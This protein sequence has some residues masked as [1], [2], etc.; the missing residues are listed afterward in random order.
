MES[1]LQDVKYSVRMFV[2][3]PAFT[4]IAVLTLALGIGANTAIFSVI[5]SVL[6]RPLPFHDPDGLVQLWETE[7]APGTYPFAGPDY[8]DWQAQNHTLEATSLYTWGRG[9]NASGAGE[10]ESAS[11]ISAQANFFS[12][13]GVQPKLGRTFA[14]GEDQEGKN[15][16]A[17]LSYG[18]WQRHFGGDLG[19]IGKPVELSSETYSVIGVMPRWFN[20]PPAT[21][22]W[23]PIDMSPKNLGN[24]GSH[25]YRALG[26][27]KPGVSINQAQADLT[28]IAKHL[29]QQYPDSNDKVG[30]AVI[31]MKEQITKSSRE[32]LLILLGAVALVLLVACANI[33]NLLLSRATGRRRELAVR[34]ALGAGRWRVVR[35]LLTESVLLALSGAGL[36]LL[37]AW[38]CVNLLQS[39]KTLPIPR[40]NAVQI[41]V[42]VL[43]FT[44][45]AGIFVGI[46]FGLA[47]AL[48]ALKLNLNEELKSSA[49]AAAGPAG[50]RRLL[51]DALVVGEIA[52][53]LALLVGAGLLLR[54]FAL[55]RNAEIGVQ[56]QN[57]L[58]M[59]INLPGKT[60]T[61]L[62]ARREFFDRLLDRIQRTPG[63]QAASVSTQI[64]L[65]GNSNG[66]ITVP[67]RDDAAIKNQLFEWNYI[68]Q[69]YFRAFDISFLQGQNFTPQDVDRVANV[70]LKI[71]ALFS[72]PNPPKELPKDLSQVA[73]I[74]R[75]M[76]RLLWPNQDAIG[77][78]FRVGGFLP[79]KVIGVVGDVKERGIRQEV[80]P[81]AYFPLT[82]ALA[83][84]EGVWRLA[85]KTSAAPMSMLGTI[86]KHVNALDSSL[87]VLRPRTMND[88]ISDAMQD[89]SLQTFLLSVFAALAV[90]LAAVGLYSVMA[91]LVTQRTHEL[92]IRMALGA[93]RN[94]VLRLVLGYGARLTV[95]GVSVGIAAA[96]ALTRLIR[97]L[98]FGVS[99][100]DF[101]TFAP[102]VI[103][104]T[105]VA[106]TACYIP[107]RRATRVDPMVALRYE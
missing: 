25:S 63:I 74:N 47:P 78:V 10:P 107:A 12:V 32:Q 13:L 98:L 46:L 72:A 103:L 65:E 44:I 89:T 38:W 22:I 33:A 45:A 67:G 93:Q 94:D 17:I 100:N 106:L 27:L 31:S 86:R 52:V 87:A 70:N 40:Q 24:R 53:S 9:F 15:H 55:M 43:L 50:S 58:T 71:K 49:Q 77:K 51:C 11:V 21:D 73:V 90:L 68:T 57:I 102:V 105:F 69:D 62:T 92:G 19:V 6:L 99:A 59:G 97:I 66:Y 82:G 80:V 5:N 91:Y 76:A 96:L 64:P 4:A 20:Y 39:A 36:G 48:Q 88:V 8:L 29:E 60:Y 16:V 2:K 61:T 34:A 14:A 1:F 35:Q 54:S 56:S 37:A 3:S 23:A 18:F 75:A 30:A 79:V 104:L 7:A 28:V 84:A 85:V 101:L 26:R 41:D 81:Q 83:Y 95:I 42:T